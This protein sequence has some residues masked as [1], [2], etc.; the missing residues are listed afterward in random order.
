MFTTLYS[1]KVLYLTFLALPNGPKVSYRNAHE[2]DFFLSLPLVILAI[3][4]IFFGYITKDLFI[5]LGTGFLDNAIFIHPNHEILINTEFG[6]PTM[7][8]LLPF[9]LTV[10]LSVLTVTIFEFIPET[11]I[12]FKM[13]RLNYYIFGFFSQGFLINML[14]NKYIVGF[15]L[16]L[17]GQ[18]T[19]VLDKGS[20]EL[21][22][23]FGLEKAL[24]QISKKITYLSSGIVT[25]Y[26]LYF[27]VGGISMMWLVL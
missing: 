15:I 19:K 24:I 10:I 27:L 3:F 7:F 5:G 13:S 11:L 16:M 21:I 6:V 8:K 12:S 26:A 14:Y 25:D 1:V 18:T 20:I 9:G 4:S 2:G 23:P 17:G 22:G